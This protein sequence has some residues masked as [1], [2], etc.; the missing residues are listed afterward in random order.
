MKT[1]FRRLL[2]VALLVLATAVPA[3]ASS[4][5][6]GYAFGYPVTYYA[7]FDL[8]AANAQVTV[9]NLTGLV[10]CNINVSG[11]FVGTL[12]VYQATSLAGLATASASL[13]ITAP[14]LYV[15]L[16]NPNVTSM[17]V[18]ATAYTSGDPVTYPDCQGGTILFAAQA[19]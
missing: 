18:K 10:Q 4:T 2:A 3:A 15:M 11:T 9:T 6:N 5:G 13:T 16:I 1:M 8:D 7:A 14:G 17:Q 19:P 12:S